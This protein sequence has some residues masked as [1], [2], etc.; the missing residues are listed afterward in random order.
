VVAVS[1]GEANAPLETERQHWLDFCEAVAKEIG[2]M[3][4]FGEL[5]FRL[6]AHDGLPYDLQRVESR[7]RYRLG[8]RAKP[9][10]GAVPAVIMQP[11]E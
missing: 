6:S 10:T 8:R 5:T 4:G 2:A 7:P 9:L 11:T 1:K 3:G